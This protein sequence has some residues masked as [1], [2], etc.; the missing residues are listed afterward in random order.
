VVGGFTNHAGSPLVPVDNAQGYILEAR[1]NLEKVAVENGV[2][3]IELRRIQRTR[4]AIKKG[5]NGSLLCQKVS[6]PVFHARMKM[7]ASNV[8]S[9]QAVIREYLYL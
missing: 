8:N 9:S 7:N 4:I 6:K 2:Y 3:S 5:A 1:S